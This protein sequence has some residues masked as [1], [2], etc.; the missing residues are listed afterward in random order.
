MPQLPTMSRTFRETQVVDAPIEP[1]PTLRVQLTQNGTSSYRVNVVVYLTVTSGIPLAQTVIAEEFVPEETFAAT[2][3]LFNVATTVTVAA[4]G[5]HPAQNVGEVMFV[6]LS[7]P[8][9]APA[10][11][12]AYVTPAGQ[13]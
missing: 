3:V 10:W 4:A 2:V 13:V 1:F 7:V 11:D 6:V 12:Q 8:A 9:R 5:V